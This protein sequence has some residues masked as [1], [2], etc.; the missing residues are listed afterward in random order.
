MEDKKNKGGRPTKYSKEFGE[1]IAELMTHNTIQDTCKIVGINSDTYYEWYHKH[2][3]FSEISTQARKTKAV[4]HFNKCEEILD[5]ID[6]KYY[7]EQIRSDLVRLKLDFHL[8]LAGKANQGL[9]GDK[10]QTEDLTKQ[11]PV[12][13]VVNLSKE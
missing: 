10:I 12:K 3:E 6:N 13:M 5:M 7:D 9:F 8:R 1:K 2:P 4:H 11:E